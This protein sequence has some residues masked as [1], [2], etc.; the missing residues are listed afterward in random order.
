M[1]VSVVMSDGHPVGID[2]VEALEE[3]RRLLAAVRDRLDGITLHHGWGTA[4]R[5]NLQAISVGAFLGEEAGPLHLTIRGLPLGVVNPIELAEQLATLDHAWNGRFA[6]GLAV[7]TMASFSSY[8]LDPAVGP[9]RFAEGLGLM[10]EMWALQPFSGTGPNFRFDE[11]RPTTRPVQEGG[12]PLSLSA[13]TT[14][15]GARSAAEHHLGVHVGIEVTSD[16]GAAVVAAYRDSGGD[17]D[18]SVELAHGD[19]TPARLSALADQGVVQVDVRL[20]EPE[21]DLSNAL[22]RVTELATNAEAVR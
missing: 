18:I 7:G 21:D 17:G 20:R 16:D 2:P 13:V 4:P 1:R 19:A 12:P 6:A 15:D 22:A 14:T 10:R 11:V 5:W 9:S 3:D 8:G